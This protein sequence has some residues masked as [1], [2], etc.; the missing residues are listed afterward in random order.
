MVES[1]RVSVDLAPVIDELRE[2]ASVVDREGVVSSEFLEKLWRHGF[3]SVVCSSEY[4]GSGLGFEGLVDVVI[5]VARYSIPVASIIGIHGTSVL[6]V[7][8]SGL[9]VVEDLCR[10]KIAGISITE[11]GG[12]SDIVST[13]RT[14]AVL[15]DGEWVVEGEKVFTSNGVYADYFLVFARTGSGERDFSLI[16]VPRSPSVVVE[17]LDLSVF[18]GAGI[19]RVKYLGARAPRE[20]VVGG[21][22]KGF[23]EA[24]RLINYGR[25]VYA[26]M[27]L[28]AVYGLLEATVRYGSGHSLFGKRLL[29]FQGPRWM[30]AHIYSRASLLESSLRE[31]VREATRTGRVDPVRA[32]MLKFEATSLAVEASRIAVQLHG[33][34]GLAAHS[35]TERMMRDSMGLVIGEGSNELLLDYISRVMVKEFSEKA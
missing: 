7:S 8:G 3:F 15:E 27:G 34:R 35:I 22:G 19:A 24:L 29:D 28:G 26:A 2:Y 9:S 5:E 12:G 21:V 17:R 6:S 10:G 32:A 14:R 31:A 13:T 20:W 25:L 23:S 11:P 18:R 4:G 30:L 1:S 33:G 16:V